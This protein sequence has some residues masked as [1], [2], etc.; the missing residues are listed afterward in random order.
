M[1]NRKIGL[2]LAG[3]TST[4]NETNH[5]SNLIEI[6]ATT[7]VL[8]YGEMMIPNSTD[9]SLHLQACGTLIKRYSWCGQPGKHSDAID[10]V[11]KEVADIEVF[12]NMGAFAKD[13]VFIADT[14]Q[15]QANLD[16]YFK[17]FMG[18]FR[19]ITSEERRRQNI[20]KTGR[21]L[22]MTDMRIWLD[23]AKNA[24]MRASNDTAWLSTIHEDEIRQRM[25]ATIRAVYHAVCI[26]SHQALAA[27]VE[28]RT[29]I[30]SSITLLENEIE[31]LTT[32]SAHM[33]S[34]DIF[35][36]LFIL[37][38]ECWQSKSKQENIEAQ[39]M[40]LLSSTGIWCNSTALRF[41]KSY[42]ESTEFHAKGSW[43]RYARETEEQN[44]PFLVF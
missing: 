33:F 5:A 19:E 36:P 39:F 8:C 7:L 23:K 17:T 40:D 34:H 41:L 32:G 35:V 30:E 27:D 25:E 20:L 14:I 26:Y 16:S 9:W 29:Q 2:E 12:R 21:S 4:T 18:L 6:M 43:I 1:L 11:V 10:F 24:Y 3:Y 37:G 15:P 38:T 44:G 22:F 31:F 42:W 28:S 13:Q